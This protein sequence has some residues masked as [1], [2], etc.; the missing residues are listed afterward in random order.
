MRDLWETIEA[1]LAP[2]V[3]RGLRPGASDKNIA[4]AEARLEV[5]F[6]EDLRASYRIHDGQDIEPGL[7]GGEG[8]MLMP[9][10]EVVERW[11]D[12]SRGNP[13][14]AS[15]VPIAWGVMSDYVFLDLDPAS[16]KPGRLMIQRRDRADPD[17]YQPSFRV[18]LDE[19]AKQLEAGEFVY[20]DEHEQIMYADELDID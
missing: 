10:R 4:T 3:L 16:E 7:V 8:W 19:F 6:P 9:L 11:G 1:R 12:W 13:K 15:Y 2:E 20:S 14:D 17:P 18:W 5:T